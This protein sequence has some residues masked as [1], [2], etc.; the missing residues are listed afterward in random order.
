MPFSFLLVLSRWAVNDVHIWTR[1]PKYSVP[2]KFWQC[3]GI[4]EAE[5]RMLVCNMR[6]HGKA[7]LQSCINRF[8]FI[9]IPRWRLVSILAFPYLLCWVTVIWKRF[10]SF[11]SLQTLHDSFIL[12]FFC[13][14]V[15]LTHGMTA[16]SP[17]VPLTC[18][19]F[20]FPQMTS[21]R[22]LQSCITP[23][24]YEIML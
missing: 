20:P 8:S 13:L 6:W 21:P 15:F 17:L 16:V 10:K 9:W 22:V 7:T 4:R 2:G 3:I 12:Q 14:S 11:C 1:Q 5:A 23:A 18:P 24:E 19:V